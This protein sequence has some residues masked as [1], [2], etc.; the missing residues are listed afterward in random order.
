MLIL[1]FGDIGVGK[2]TTAK[3]L[4]E[5]FGFRLVQFDT[6]VPE[7]TGKTEMYGKN[8]EFL[9]TEEEERQVHDAMLLVAREGLIQGENVIMESMFFKRERDQAVAYA[10]AMGVVCHLVEVVCDL[11]ENLHRVEARFRHNRQSAGVGLF[12]EYRG[13]LRDETREHIVLDTT[14]K[15]VDA[16]AEEIC[17]KI[18]L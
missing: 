4:S 2:S 9:L 15:D 10:E 6:L 11:E 7:V 1:L 5:R 3:A 18:R 13:Q 12:L 14:R 16:C 8:N 17:R